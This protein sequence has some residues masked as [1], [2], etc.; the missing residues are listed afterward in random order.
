MRGEEEEKGRAHE[1]RERRRREGAALFRMKT[2]IQTDNFVKELREKISFQSVF[3]NF[4]V[5]LTRTMLPICHPCVDY[6]FFLFEKLSENQ[7]LLRH[8]IDPTEFG[9]KSLVLFQI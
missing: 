3:L 6:Y 5:I 2:N 1:C 9:R 7:G 8:S 4:S